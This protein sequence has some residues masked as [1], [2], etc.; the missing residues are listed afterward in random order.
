MAWTY[1][2]ADY[3]EN[4]TDYIQDENWGSRKP[5]PA[6][7]VKIVEENVVVV[8]SVSFTVLVIPTEVVYA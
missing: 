6:V 4:Q 2:D 7:V 3:L 1:L 5:S 8:E